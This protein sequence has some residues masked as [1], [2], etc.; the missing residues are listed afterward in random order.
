MD[1]SNDPDR[2]SALRRVRGVMKPEPPHAT[3]SGL[4][5]DHG[6]WEVRVGAFAMYRGLGENARAWARQTLPG[7]CGW[8]PWRSSGGSIVATPVVPLAAFATSL[9]HSNVASR[10]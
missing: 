5:P 9:A 8:R 2:A 1:P 4:R 3:C 7:A 10:T 6:G